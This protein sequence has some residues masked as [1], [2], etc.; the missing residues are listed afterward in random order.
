MDRLNAIER[1]IADLE[2]KLAACRA[3]IS[4][5]E[6][7]DP[8]AVAMTASLERARVC[9]SEL[10]NNIALTLAVSSPHELA[11]RRRVLSADRSRVGSGRHRPDAGRRGLGRRA[12][13]RRA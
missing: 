12:G 1:A 6:G 8:Q 13:L 10:A 7:L 9:A 4:D 3:A 5:A 11:H 2:V